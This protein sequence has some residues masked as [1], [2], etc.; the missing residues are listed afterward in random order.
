M[1]NRSRRPRVC[2]FAPVRDRALL[3]TVE[4]YAQD[5]TIL[6]ELGY[7]VQIATRWREIPWGCDLYFIWWWTWA[8]LPLLKS[9]LSGRPAVITGTFEFLRFPERPRYQRWLI[10][11]AYRFADVNVPVSTLELEWMRETMP[12]NHVVYIPHAV[13]SSVYSAGTGDRENFCLTVAW[14]KRENAWRKC[15]AELI[16][17]VP[18]IRRDLPGLKFVIAGGLEDGGSDMI[19]LA[20]KLGVADVIEFPGRI[21]VADKI[22]MM[23]TCQIY[24]QPSRDEGFGVAIAEAL[25]CGA[26]VVTSPVG[27]VPEVVGDCAEYV[28]GTDP[29]SIAA[30]VIRLARSP[31]LRRNRSIE[32]QERVRREFSMAR[33]REGLAAVMEPLLARR[34]RAPKSSVSSS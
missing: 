4:F 20:Q 28:D 11:N 3:E 30:G 27:A 8:F 6:N 31:E 18:L 22:R 9:R 25:C 5:L 14:M 34:E 21:D 17:A 29:E 19:D 15:V 32:G 2:F 12:A 16:R 7:D 13:D 33:R 1:S 26:P 24:L 23:Q 10:R